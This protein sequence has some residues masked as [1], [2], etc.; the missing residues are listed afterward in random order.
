MSHNHKCGATTISGGTCK[1]PVPE[2]RE[3]CW[4]HNGPQCSVCFNALSNRNTRTLPCNHEFHTKC[5]DRWKRTC[6]PG[7]PTC[8]MCRSPF[9]LPK[10]RCRLTVERVN[11]ANTFTTDF[12]TSNINS[13]VA[14]FGFDLREMLQ[15]LYTDIHFDIDHDEDINYILQELG[16]PLPPDNF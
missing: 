12:Q 16:L 13:I 4:L 1:H 14:G 7:D 8:P 11:E 9:D 3:H 10:Y 2:G 6:A 5:V 15:G